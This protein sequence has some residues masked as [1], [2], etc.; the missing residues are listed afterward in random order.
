M[1]PTAPSVTIPLDHAATIILGHMSGFFGRGTLYG[2]LWGAWK[3]K[4]LA[5]RGGA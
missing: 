1:F 2:G 3:W 5:K 4:L